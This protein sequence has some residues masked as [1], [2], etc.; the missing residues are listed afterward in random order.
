[1]E[2]AEYHHLLSLLNW[3]LELGATETIGDAP[4]NRYDLPKAQSKAKAQNGAGKP[5]PGVV[6]MQEPDAAAEA[7]TIARAAQTLEELRAAV[8]GFTLCDLKKGARSTVFSDGIPGA[9][10]MIVGEAPDR[11]ED[12]AGRPFV[13]ATGAMLDRMFGAI[14]LGREQ[15]EAPLYLTSVLPWRLPQG[16]EA[17][18]E[19]IAMM[20]PFLLRHIALAKPEVLVIMGNAAAQALLGKRG[21]TRLRGTWAE[22]AGLPAMPMFHPGTL[23]RTP[24]MKR[25]AWGDLLEI[26]ARLGH[27]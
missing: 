21:L 17:R 5:T 11:E 27:G 6:R 2:S 1:M 9:R 3:Q 20:R 25:I 16:R 18:P 7:Q 10:V 19:E 14:G 13:G 23:L 15:A 26:K 24:A 22:V 12:R 8:E 4:V